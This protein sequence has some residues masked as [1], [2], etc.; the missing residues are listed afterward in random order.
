MAAWSLARFHVACDVGKK[1]CKACQKQMSALDRHSRCQKCRLAGGYTQHTKACAW[2]S[3]LFI[4]E[5]AGRKFCSVSCSQANRGHI[6][7]RWAA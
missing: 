4:G 6:S 1:R 2:C 7:G 5:K 3:K